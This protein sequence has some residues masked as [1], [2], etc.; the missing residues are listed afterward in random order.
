LFDYPVGLLYVGA[1]VADLIRHNARRGDFGAGTDVEHEVEKRLRHLRRA[2]EYTFERHRADGQVI[3]MVGGPMPGGGYVT[4]FI[5]ITAEAQVRAELKRTL[6][7]METRVAERTHELSRRTS[8]WRRRIGTRRAFWPRPAM[9]CCSRCMPHACLRRRWRAMCRIIRGC[10]S[11]GWTMRLLRPRIFCAP[12]STF[13]SWMRAGAGAARTL[14][15]ET[16]LRDLVENFR[17]M[18]QERGWNCVWP[19]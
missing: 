19:G 4:S 3:K 1:P 10:W 18:A 6:A 17:P 7:G 8:V 5:D 14:L 15:V 11:G 12:C 13:P 2:Q 16:F 9:I